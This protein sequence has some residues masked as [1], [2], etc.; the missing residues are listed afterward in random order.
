MPVVPSGTLVPPVKETDTAE[1]VVLR[2]PCRMTSGPNVA[3]GPLTFSSESTE[4]L[5]VVPLMSTGAA[6]TSLTL[7]LSIETALSLAV[8][9]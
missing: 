8:L 7:T 1:P 3:G 6:P 4:T 2:M 9:T 5:I